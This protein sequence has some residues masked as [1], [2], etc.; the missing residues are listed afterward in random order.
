MKIRTRGAYHRTVKKMPNGVN[1]EL[2]DENVREA[3]D[4]NWKQT[5]HLDKLRLRLIY[6][7]VVFVGAVISILNIF[8]PLS[9]PGI[10]LVTF[11]GGFSLM[12]YSTSLKWNAE[13]SNHFAAAQWDSYKLGLIN[14]MEEADREEL[15]NEIE[16]TELTEVPTYAFFKE[17]YMAL[18]LP[19]SARTHEYLHTRLPK[20]IS[21]ITFSLAA[22]LIS[23]R[24]VSVINIIPA[25]IRVNE[26]TTIQGPHLIGVGALIPSIIVGCLVWDWCESVLSDIRNQSEIFIQNRKPEGIDWES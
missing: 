13:H 16:G 14:E 9:I 10:A 17:A 1:D 12:V 23:Y 2:S 15:I 25:L 7:F 5:R 19:L 21:V 3:L 8:D 11:L 6:I 22:F 4:Q 20:Y 24:A 18:P 26:S